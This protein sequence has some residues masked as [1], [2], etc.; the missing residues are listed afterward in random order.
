MK[1]RKVS[2]ISIDEDS[3]GETSSVFSDQIS[4]QE[5]DFSEIVSTPD[6]GGLDDI[7]LTKNMPWI[8]VSI[9][10]FVVRTFTNV[11]YQ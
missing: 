2:S 5:Q 3:T 1:G 11:D 6:G 4:P 9:K 7:D 8:P 10:Q